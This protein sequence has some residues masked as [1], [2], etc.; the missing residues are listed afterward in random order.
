MAFERKL[1]LVAVVVSVLAVAAA[2]ILFF[3][4]SAGN[5]TT[6][7]DVKP[8]KAV[9][10]KDLANCIKEGE[11]VDHP[12]KDS[13]YCCPGLVKTDARP[14]DENCEV[15]IPENSPG[16]ESGWACIK[17]GDGIC[18]SQYENKC[19]CPADCE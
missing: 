18:G 7:K 11:Y 5:T 6:T 2:V 3:I 12:S 9:I 13:F 14:L 19:N 15:I 16:I 4:Y 10:K 17:C 1:L 8:D